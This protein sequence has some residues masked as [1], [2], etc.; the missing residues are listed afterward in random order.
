ML[1]RFTIVALLLSFVGC[2]GAAPSFDRAAV[3][4]T[5]TA[6]GEPLPA[7][8]V[9]FIPTEANQ[10]QMV[11]A[12]IK[13]GAYALSANEGPAV[14]RCRVEITAMR[15]TGE[16]EEVD[17]VKQEIE[18]QYI[19]AKYNIESSLFVEIKPGANQHDFELEF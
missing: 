16:T 4:G 2:E 11:F 10:G 15:K 14:G 12:P 8:S 7:G 19:P 5:V 13:E 3:S 6:N 9:R 17:G 18:E 1:A